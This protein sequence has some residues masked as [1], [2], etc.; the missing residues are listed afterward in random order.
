MIIVVIWRRIV[1]EEIGLVRRVGLDEP[2]KSARTRVPDYRIVVEGVPGG[3]Q[4]LIWRIATVPSVGRAYH[5]AADPW[6]AR[7]LQ[8]FAVDVHAGA[9]AH[10]DL[11]T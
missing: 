10:R 5:P 4:I 9:G 3:C 8:Y 7:N 2:D 1:G 6:S 11:K